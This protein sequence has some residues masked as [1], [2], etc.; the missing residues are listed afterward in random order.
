MRRRKALVMLAEDDA[1]QRRALSNW[2]QRE[3]HEVVEVED[4][5]G[6]RQFIDRALADEPTRRVHVLVTDLQM[7]NVG[8]LDVLAYMEDLGLHLPTVVVTGY[9]S[10]EALAEARRLG[11]H[12]VLQKPIDTDELKRILE[13]L[14]EGPRS[15]LHA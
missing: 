2:L 10:Q 4:G 6:V 12:A 15:V 7:P 8:G 5:E 9:P 14:I 13:E 11:A 3:G 1:D